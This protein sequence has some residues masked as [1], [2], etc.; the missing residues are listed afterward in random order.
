MIEFVE[1]IGSFLAFFS[2]KS[3]SRVESA[4]IGL[5]DVELD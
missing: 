4:G 5:I 3:E 1:L 2:L